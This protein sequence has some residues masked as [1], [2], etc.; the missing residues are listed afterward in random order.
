[1]STIANTKELESYELNQIP[2]LKRSELQSLCKTHSIRANSKN[3]VLIK[4]LQNKWKE[5]TDN[6][7]LQNK[8]EKHSQS[9]KRGRK[10]YDD[11]EYDDEDSVCNKPKRKKRKL[12]QTK[13]KLNKINKLNKKIKKL[14]QEK[15]TKIYELKTKQ[16]KEMESL[17]TKQKKEMESLLSR[18]D[19]VIDTKVC[20]RQELINEIEKESEIIICVQCHNEVENTKTCSGCNGSVCSGC[21]VECDGFQIAG[22]PCPN[23]AIYCDECA[24]D[25]LFKKPCGHNECYTCGTRKIY[26]SLRHN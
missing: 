2:S 9:R 5:L 4:N 7:K 8:K 24:E 15:N 18:L 22:T 23:D 19:Q 14:K 1:M 25:A 11:D 21:R 16:K 3:T 12:N 20:D 13:N 26:Y 17:K 10:Q 6:K